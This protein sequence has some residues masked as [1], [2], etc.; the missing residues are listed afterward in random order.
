MCYSWVIR[1]VMT[2]RRIKNPDIPRIA[3]AFCLIMA[4]RTLRS[5]GCENFEYS[6]DSYFIELKWDLLDLKFSWPW[7][8]RLLPSGVL[9]HLRWWM[10]QSNLPV[11]DASMRYEVFTAVNNN[12]WDPEPYRLTQLQALSNSSLYVARI[13]MKVHHTLS[14]QPNVSVL[15]K[16]P[17][18]NMDSRRTS[19]LYSSSFVMTTCWHIALL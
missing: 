2:H 17:Q 13:S 8:W 3:V 16:H 5:Q 9:R 18:D 14:R 11:D 10:S 6:I 4:F 19:K 1:E 12:I 15:Q 7:P